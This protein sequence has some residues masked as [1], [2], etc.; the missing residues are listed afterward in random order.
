[1]ALDHWRLVQHIKTNQTEARR[2]IARLEIKITAAVQMHYQDGLAQLSSKNLPAARNRFL[3]ALR[4]NPDFQPALKQVVTRFSPFPLAVYQS[5][6]GDQPASVAKKV[7]G[8]ADKAFLVAWFNDLPEDAALNPGTLLILPK[9]E[10]DPPRQ[11]I[12]KQPPDQLAEARARLADNDLDGALTQAEQAKKNNPAAQAL[13]HTIR[14]KMATS[15]IESNQ[16]E[17][18]R[19]SLAL[20]PDGVTGKAAALETLQIALYEQQTSLILKSARKHFDQGDYQQSIDGVERLLKEAPGN[21]D[22]RDLAAESRY[23]LALDHLDH[24]RLLEARQVLEKNDAGHGASMALKETVRTRL[25]EMAQI[26]YRNGVKHFINQDLKSAIAEWEMA[27]IC[28][29]Q[30][31]KARENITNTHR[32]MQKLETLP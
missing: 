30:H 1:M 16:L 8:D 4:L 29:P 7:F 31:E 23:R 17:A 14:L 32:L 10:K 9:L 21:A 19:Q 12:N 26:H 20:I 11:A 5:E 22:A 24:K 2:E 25:A 6:S 18:A 13:I 27:L 28:N 3:A 15:Q